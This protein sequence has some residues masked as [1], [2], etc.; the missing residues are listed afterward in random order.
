MSP[1]ILVEF[2]VYS[3][4]QYWRGEAAF[5]PAYRKCACGFGHSE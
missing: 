1:H 2:Q 5:S 3:V 4:F